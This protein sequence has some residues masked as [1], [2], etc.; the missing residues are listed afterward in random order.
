MNCGNSS[1]ASTTESCPDA[2]AALRIDAL[3]L[4]P[5]PKGVPMGFG[6]HQDDA[7]PVRNGGRGEATHR[8]I[9]KFL[10]LIELHDVIARPGTGQ[11]ATPWLTFIVSIS[12]PC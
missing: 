11:Q 7:L 8:A 3:G 6:R 12:H 4:E 9:E 2:C 5:R 10:V 1:S